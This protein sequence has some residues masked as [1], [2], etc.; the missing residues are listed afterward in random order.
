MVKIFVLLF[1]FLL[2]DSFQVIHACGIEQSIVLEY[3]KKAKHDIVSVSDMMNIFT[4]YLPFMPVNICGIMAKYVKRKFVQTAL[5]KDP[6]WFYPSKYFSV[7]FVS[8]D[9]IGAG[10]RAGSIE[11]WNIKTKKRIAMPYVGCAPT[12]VVTC[13]PQSQR[14][15]AGSEKGD[16][17]SFRCVPEGTLKLNNWKSYISKDLIEGCSSRSQG[18]ISSLIHLDQDTL[19]VGNT[20]KPVSV[21]KFSAKRKTLINSLQRVTCLAKITSDSFAAIV[22]YKVYLMDIR[23]QKPFI[24][25]ACINS[26]DMVNIDGSTIALK[27]C[28]I[29]TRILRK[30]GPATIE[31]FDIRKG[32]QRTNLTIG[33]GLVGNLA[34]YGRHLVFDV[35]MTIKLW[36]VEK[37]Q[38]IEEIPLKNHVKA[39]ATHKPSSSLVA[40]TCN[41]GADLLFTWHKRVD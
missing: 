18:S 19:V 8:E 36:N 38:C 28:P 16:V 9:I 39:L 7:T 4:V 13:E 20:E 35:N 1:L 10:S 6:D 29:G 15:V 5:M 40:A 12:S 30:N 14:I 26:S 22:D 34:T 24:L 11:L 33:A 23:V 2:N 17:T 3:D 21:Y 41:D 37:D 32:T 31:I 25:E 27:G